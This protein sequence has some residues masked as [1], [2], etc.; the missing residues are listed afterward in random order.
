MRVG[1]SLV[2]FGD[3]GFDDLDYAGVGHSAKITELIALASDDFTH[4]AAHDLF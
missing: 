4:D 2:G 1:R 3:L